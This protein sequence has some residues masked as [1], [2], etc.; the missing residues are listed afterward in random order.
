MKACQRVSS[1][2]LYRACFHILSSRLNR[3]F[4]CNSSLW[5]PETIM[6]LGTGTEKRQTAFLCSQCS[7][8]YTHSSEKESLGLEDTVLIKKASEKC[9]GRLDRRKEEGENCW[10]KC[11]KILISTTNS[12]LVLPSTTTSHK[13]LEQDTQLSI[14]K[15]PLLQ[16]SCWESHC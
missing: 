5:L 9:M 15:I 16:V 12:N 10:E 2:I 6:A 4:P 7:S 1:N 3:A 13:N 11:G 14:F 8:C